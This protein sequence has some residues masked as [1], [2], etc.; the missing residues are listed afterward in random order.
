MA[1]RECVVIV[2]GGAAGMMAA[3]AAR[4]S[5]PAFKVI[6]VEHQEKLGRKLLVCGAGRCNLTNVNVRP[7]RFAGASRAFVRTVLE[8]FD[9]TAVRSFFEDLG[10]SLYEEKKNDKGKLFPVTNQAQT[11]LSLLVDELERE[12]VE[13][14]L[15][16]HVSE[17]RR[18]GEGF[19][20]RTQKGRMWG[21]RLILAAGGKTYPKLGG[22]GSGY[23]LARAFGHMIVEP[24]PTAL[25]LLAPNPISKRLHG[26]RAE[27]EVAA[28]VGGRKVCRDV[29]QMMF[30]KYGFTGPVILNVSRPIS[31]RI[32]RERKTDCELELKFLPGR[33]RSEIRSEL[34]RRWKRR[35]AQRLSL[36]LCGLLQGKLPE[37]I[38]EHLRIGDAPVQDVPARDKDALAR[39]LSGWRVPVQGTRGWDEGEFTA[40]G[41]DCSEVDPRSLRSLRVPGLYFAGEVLDVDG[42]VGGFNLTWAWSSGHVAGQLG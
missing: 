28:V 27:M 16:V 24:V 11:V 10:V 6:L 15:G 20:L 41:V 1:K 9:H 17:A 8:R 42:E 23:A 22:D 12:G 37:A 39:F 19:Q 21:T 5:R 30:V 33:S 25:P 14:R 13:I 36:S 29:D 7:E 35:P 32:H 26:V 18:D 4:R 40:G 3:L 38:L 31:L 34:A 2:G